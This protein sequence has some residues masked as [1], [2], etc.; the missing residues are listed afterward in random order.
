MLFTFLQESRYCNRIATRIVAYGSYRSI[1]VRHKLIQLYSRKFIVLR[2]HDIH[3]HI[4][5]AATFISVSPFSCSFSIISV[6]LPKYFKSKK[7]L[8]SLVTLPVGK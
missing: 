8:R 2:N 7:T 4:S 3:A 6:S 5:T 1:R